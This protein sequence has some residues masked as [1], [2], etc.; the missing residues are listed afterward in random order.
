MKDGEGGTLQK[1][2]YRKCEGKRELF[3]VRVRRVQ[4]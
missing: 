2:K 3:K 1:K 4:A